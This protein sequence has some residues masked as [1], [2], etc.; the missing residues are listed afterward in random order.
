MRRA[1]SCV[2]L[3]CDD[4]ELTEQVQSHLKQQLGWP[5]FESSFADVRDHNRIKKLIIDEARAEDHAI[6]F[7]AVPGHLLRLDNGTRWSVV[8]GDGRLLTLA[9][10][11]VDGQAVLPETYFRTI[12]QRFGLDTETLLQ[13]IAA[14]KAG[15]LEMQAR[16]FLAGGH[17]SLDHVCGLVDQVVEAAAARLRDNPG[18]AVAN[19][20]RNYSFQKRFF[21]WEQRQRWFGIQV[22]RSF[23]F[24]AVAGEPFAL[25]YWL[26][27]EED[28]GIRQRIYL[29]IKPACAP[30]YAENA[31]R[32]FNEAFPGYTVHSYVPKSLPTGWFA[33]I[34]GWTPAQVID[35]LSRLGADLVTRL[36][37]F[38]EHPGQPLLSA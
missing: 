7:C 30:L 17:L 24:T 27:S 6:Q 23:R 12:R 26:F 3:V 34:T 32:L 11:R 28:R 37:V 10:V 38:G 21:D 15:N 16:A 35:S 8:C 1:G 9:K 18:R 20:L 4:R 29:S 2:A 33:D 36:G 19:P 25:G 31:A 22:Y 13:E 14:C 5:A